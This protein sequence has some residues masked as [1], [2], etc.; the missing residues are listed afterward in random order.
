[1]SAYRE[2]DCTTPECLEYVRSCLAGGHTLAKHLCQRSDLGSGRTVTFL[3]DDLD[4]PLREFTTQLAG[5]LWLSSSEPRSWLLRSIRAFLRRERGAVVILELDWRAKRTIDEAVSWESAAGLPP[6]KPRVKCFR[7][8]GYICLFES[9]ADDEAIIQRS[10]D[11]AC[12]LRRFMGAATSHPATVNLARD[13]NEITGEQLSVLAKRAESMFFDAYDGEGYA[14]W[15]APES[16]AS[17]R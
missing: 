1:M 4:A 8:E 13:E 15:R 3:P 5:G 2:F 12:I 17:G 7:D 16:P 11:A 6:L 14:I 10:V 9:D